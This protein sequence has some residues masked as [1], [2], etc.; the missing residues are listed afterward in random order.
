[1]LHIGHIVRVHPPSE[2]IDAAFDGDGFGESRARVAMAATV[3]AHGAQR[4]LGEGNKTQTI[5]GLINSAN[6][7]EAARL[8]SN[9]LLAHPQS[10]AALSLL[11]Y[12]QYMAQDY[13]AAAVT[14][15]ALVK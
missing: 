13:E 3:N 7:A 6:Y 15:N 12:C 5:Y 8:L 14:Y 10:R 2:K 9:E 11:G 1:M 4:S